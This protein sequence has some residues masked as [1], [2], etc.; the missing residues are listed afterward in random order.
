[1]LLLLL[2][3]APVG[4][5]A[6]RSSSWGCLPPITSLPSIPAVVVI[7][8]VLDSTAGGHSPGGTEIT[9]LSLSLLSSLSFGAGGDDVMR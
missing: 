4:R 1:M 7:S 6:D 3:V 9:K 5:G 8:L 2:A